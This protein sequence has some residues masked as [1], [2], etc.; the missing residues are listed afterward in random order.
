MKIKNYNSFKIKTDLVIH[1]N[2]CYSK[3]EA[4]TKTTTTTND[5]TL[6][7]NFIDTQQPETLGTNTLVIVQEEQDDYYVDDDYDEDDDLNHYDNKENEALPETNQIETLEVNSNQN[8]HLSVSFFFLCYVM[9][10]NLF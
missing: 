3:K 4:P 2:G 10:W 8:K 6:F 7:S 5:T 9:F 1:S